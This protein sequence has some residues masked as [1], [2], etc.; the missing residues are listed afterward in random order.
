[1]WEIFVKGGPVMIPLAILSVVG[2]AVVIEKFV[3]LRNSKVIH[4]EVINCIESVRSAADIPMAIKLC[5]RH[6]SPFAEIVRS[7]LEAHALPPLEIR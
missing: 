3:N 1:M 7:G 2:L 6:H 4:S 5:E